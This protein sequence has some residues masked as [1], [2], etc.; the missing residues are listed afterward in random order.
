MVL[1]RE[2]DPH[3]PDLGWDRSLPLPVTADAVRAIHA[4][5]DA[6][7]LGAMAGAARS[8]WSAA[9]GIAI[10]ASLGAACLALG[11]NIAAAVL[12]AMVAPATLAT[13]EA[14]RRARQWQGVI[15]AR[16]TILGGAT[17]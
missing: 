11:W 5:A 7:A 13:I 14:R 2:L 9:G 8:Y 1:Y 12:F 17:R 3:L 15:E 6:G 4:C 16:L 10:G